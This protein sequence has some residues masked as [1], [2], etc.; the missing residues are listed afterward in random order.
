M[1]AK[2]KLSELVAAQSRRKTGNWAT[3]VDDSKAV[4]EATDMLLEIA[5]AALAWRRTDRSEGHAQRDLQ[6]KDFDCE[7]APLIIKGDRVAEMSGDFVFD[8]HT[9]CEQCPAF[10]TAYPVCNV[11]E[12][13][14]EFKVTV[15]NGRIASVEPTAPSTAQWLEREP[16][17]DYMQGARGPM[18]HAEAVALRDEEYRR[19][20]EE[21]K[22]KP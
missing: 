19:K 3:M 18:T 13:W 7:L 10:V 12:P 5:Q 20:Q 1:T 22:G 2:V 4:G 11:I 9:S 17:E 15:K 21:R 6:S 14:V 8:V 16:K